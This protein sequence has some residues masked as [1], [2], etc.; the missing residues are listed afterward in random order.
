M[1]KR[2]LSMM[3]TLI[4]VSICGCGFAACGGDGG[5][6]S[7]S[8]SQEAEPTTEVTAEE[9]AASMENVDNVTMAYTVNGSTMTVK[10][11]GTKRSQNKGDKEQIFVKEG[12]SYFSYS[13]FSGSWVKSSITEETYNYSQNMAQA[14]TVFQGDF[15]A[16]EYVGGK[17]VAETL[18]KMQTMNGVLHNVEITFE[19][20]ALVRIAFSG[21]DGESRTYDYEIGEFGTTTITLPTEFTE[22]V[23]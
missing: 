21:T 3:A 9:W 2:I 13:N 20:G 8:S 4:C 18:D 11:D 22:D 17:Y 16:F 5:K 7:G 23:A 1:K 10:I 15:N 14:V 12:D 19:N 6:E